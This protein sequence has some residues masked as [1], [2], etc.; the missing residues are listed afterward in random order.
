MKQH[1]LTQWIFAILLFILVVS[2]AA[3]I[4]LNFNSLFYFD[5]E[6]LKMEQTT[7]MSQADMKENYDALISYNQFWGPKKLE[8]PTL[9]MS[10]SGE[11]HFKEVKSVFLGLEAVG[12]FSLIAILVG[13]LKKKI[14]IIALKRAGILMLAIPAFL[15]AVMVVSWDWLFTTFHQVVFGNEDWLFDPVTDPVIQMLPEEFFLHGAVMIFVIV[16]LCSA[17]CFLCYRK[18]R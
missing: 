12:I 4:T 9:P 2:S 11:K 3:T 14:K 5:I 16:L 17:G 18:K 8:F 10:Q 15:G 13:I 1:K 7:G 6:Y